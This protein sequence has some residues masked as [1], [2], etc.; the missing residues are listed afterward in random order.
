MFTFCN[1]G[2][3]STKVCCDFWS[4]HLILLFMRLILLFVPFVELVGL[5]D[6]LFVV[7]ESLVV[8]E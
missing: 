3:A 7:Y 4:V 2:I 6:A 8:C 5:V 1:Y